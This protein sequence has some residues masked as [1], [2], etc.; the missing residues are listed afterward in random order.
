MA[1][2]VRPSA[3]AHDGP[4]AD[5]LA[6]EEGLECCGELLVVPFCS[7]TAVE[8]RTGRTAAEDPRRRETGQVTV[9]RYH[10]PLLLVKTLSPVS[11]RT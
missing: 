3:L 2:H 7:P 9:A 4:G 6:V 1:E 10:R 5:P 11:R 8:G